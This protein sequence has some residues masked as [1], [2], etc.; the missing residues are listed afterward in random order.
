MRGMA[1]D[2]LARVVREIRERRVAAR[3][4]Y[5]E[6]QRLERALVALDAAPRSSGGSQTD[7][8]RRARPP[9][10]RRK[11]ATPGANRAAI[12]AAVRAGPGASAGEVALVT[13]IPRSTV[14]PT[15]SR[16][17]A[18]GSVERTE[19]R[20]GGVGFRPAAEQTAAMA[21]EGG[22]GGTAAR[23]AERQGASRRRVQR[24]GNER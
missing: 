12:L 10:R 23:S 22:D 21:A 3:A 14:A 6:S 15:L 16:L 13:G 11:P 2:L 5:E 24:S 1:E 8:S 9:G 7:A 4:A 19:L 18:A 20:G 17:I